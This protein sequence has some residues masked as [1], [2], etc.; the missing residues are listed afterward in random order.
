MHRKEVIELYGIG[1]II[2]RLINDTNMSQEQI[3]VIIG[4]PGNQGYVSKC[5]RNDMEF[6]DYELLQ[7]MNHFKKYDEFVNLLHCYMLGRKIKPVLDLV[8]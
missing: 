2:R 1:S 6:K 4:K 5:L 3:A 8:S 7:L